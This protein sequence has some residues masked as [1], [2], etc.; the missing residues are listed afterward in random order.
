MFVE[1]SGKSAVQMEGG[2]RNLLNGSSA[3]NST[4]TMLSQ[5][6]GSSVLCTR[7]GGETEQKDREKGMLDFG[8]EKEL[9]VR[10]C[11]RV[12]EDFYLL[13]NEQNQVPSDIADVQGTLSF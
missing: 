7:K 5:C 1:A 4:A 3:A 11:Y 2:E 12:G 6:L 13:L 9:S 8:G 10:E